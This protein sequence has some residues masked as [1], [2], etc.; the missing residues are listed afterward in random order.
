M[1]QQHAVRP[2]IASDAEGFSSGRVLLEARLAFKG[3][4]E[5]GLVEGECGVGSGGSEIIQGSAPIGSEQ[6]P[7]FCVFLLQLEVFFFFNFL[8]RAAFPEALGAN[9]MGSYALMTAGWA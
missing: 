9:M 7:C 4:F 6:E 2:H 5:G 8:A 3:A 1:C